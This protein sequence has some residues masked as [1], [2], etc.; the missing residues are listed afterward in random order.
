MKTEIQKKLMFKSI[1]TKFLSTLD[2][3]KITFNPSKSQ[4]RR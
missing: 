4:L 1:Q 3:G 2:E